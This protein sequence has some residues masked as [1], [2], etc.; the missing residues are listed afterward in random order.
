MKERRGRGGRDEGE[1]GG[2]KEWRERRRKR[3]R[4]EGEEGETKERREG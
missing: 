2:M 4:D 1:E 3:G